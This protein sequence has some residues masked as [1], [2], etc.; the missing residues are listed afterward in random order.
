MYHCVLGAAIAVAAGLS[1]A[2]TAASAA[3]G[4]YVPLF[5]YR[6]G[7]FAASGTPIVNG[8]ADYLNMLNERDG[9]INGVK[10]N[11]EEC[12]TSY[13]TKKGLECYEQV[14]S[15]HPVVINPYSTGI[16][17]PLIPKAAVDKIP[18]L[19]LAYGLSASADGNTFPWIFNPPATY[20]DG[21][22]MFVRYV[23]GKEGGLDKLK[24]K[25]L[26]LIYLDAPYGKEPIPVLGVGQG[27]WVRTQALS[28]AGRGNAEPV[29]AVAQ[30]P[31]RPSGLALSPGL[32]HHEPDR[33]Q[34]SRQEQ[35]PHGSPDRQ[36]VGGWR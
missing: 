16:T 30:H 5:A 12:E 34:G 22:S 11:V 28:G 1:L 33:G 35:L 8:M 14:K 23:A 26:G 31:P 20:W 32:R 27:L 2:P 9:G 6:T 21:A 15:K 13:D 29:V 18:L 36:L 17:L 7:P 3:D 19:S 25:K 4:I 10:I 24:G